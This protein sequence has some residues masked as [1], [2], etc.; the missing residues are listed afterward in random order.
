MGIETPPE[1]PVEHP[2]TLLQ[3]SA[4]ERSHAI[5]RSWIV[6]DIL[7]P[8]VATRVMLS[9]VGWLALLSFQNLPANPGSWELKPGGEIAVAA[10]YLSTTSHPFLNMYA[11]WDGGWYHSIA[12][13]GYKFEPGRQSNTA[14]FPLYPMLMRAVHTLIP[15]DTDAAWVLA[16]IIVSN[17]AF[18]I[19]LCYL[20]LLL[21]LDYDHDTSAR[22]VLYLLVFPTAFFFFALYSESLFLATTVAAF[23]YARR[24][25]WWF[26]AVCAA[27]ATLSRSSGVLLIAPL[28]LEYAMQRRFRWREIRADVLSL[29]LIPTALAAHMLY[30]RWSVGNMRAIQDAQAAWGGEWGTFSAPWTPFVRFLRD[31]LMFNDVMNFGFAGVMLLLVAISAA[32]LRLSYGVYAITGFWFITSWSTYE[33]MPRYVLVLFPAFAVLA[34]WGRNRT[35]DRAYLI[36]AC[37]LAALFMMR[38]ALWRWVA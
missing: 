30:L 2:G 6:R 19:A 33:S 16:G 27:A 28:A 24:Q 34:K 26:A 7:V 13:H 20:L 29:G 4:R 8:F 32:Q 23:Y 38:F 11:R 36:T 22:A 18:F 35:F 9:F 17:A 5:A 15:S 14:F 3:R 37:G 10:P 25:K 1:R 31:P 21:R 12:K